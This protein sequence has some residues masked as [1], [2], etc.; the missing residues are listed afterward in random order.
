MDSNETVGIGRLAERIGVTPRA[1]RHYEQQGLI[2]PIRKPNGY[3]AYDRRMAIRA[4]NIKSLLDL[5]LSSDDIR[6]QIEE[7][8]LDEPLADRPHCQAELTPIQARL[9]TLN[10]LIARLERT[11]D[12]LHAHSTE[13]AAS[14]GN[15]A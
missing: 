9:D 5:G 10:E 8:C 6:P 11:R 15:E 2:V 12:R 14:L 7:G 13:V 4:A 1:L 3:R